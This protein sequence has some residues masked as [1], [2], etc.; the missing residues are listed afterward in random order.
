MARPAATRAVDLG[1]GG[2]RIRQFREGDMV[3]AVP[4]PTAARGGPAEACA[5]LGGACGRLYPCK[6][7]RSGGGP[8]PWEAAL[9]S[10]NVSVPSAFAF[11]NARLPAEQDEGGEGA[12]A[13]QLGAGEVAA[14]VRES[15]ASSAGAGLGSLA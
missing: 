14:M 15:T 1:R 12:A 11:F 5:A 13:A 6:A 7:W 3:F 2:A 9:V 4:A 10:T 8:A